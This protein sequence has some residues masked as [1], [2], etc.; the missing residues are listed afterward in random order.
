MPLT[1]AHKVFCA[2]SKS[3]ELCI[4][5]TLCGEEEPLSDKDIKIDLFHSSGAGGQNVNKV[6]TAVRVTHIPTGTVVVCQ[7]ER[8]QLKNKQRAVETLK[9]RLK[10]ARATTEKE[11]MEADIAAQFRKKN[12]PISFDLDDMTMTD[13]RLKAYARAAFPL[14]D[15]AAYINGLCAL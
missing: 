1:G 2:H 15:M 6:E 10:D 7:D 9:K 5:A 3:E 12:T 4:A 11:R 8:S 13:T 14:E